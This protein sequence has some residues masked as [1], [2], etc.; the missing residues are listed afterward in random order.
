V[1]EVG[2]VGVVFLFSI[3]YIFNFRKL[4]NADADGISFSELAEDE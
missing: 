4:R 3:L 1:G 2:D